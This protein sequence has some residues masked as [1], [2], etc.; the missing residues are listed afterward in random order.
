[1]DGPYAGCDLTHFRF[2]NGDLRRTF[3][4][5]QTVL[6]GGFADRGLL[7]NPF[8]FARGVFLVGIHHRSDKLRLLFRL[9][10][11]HDQG[12]DDAEDHVQD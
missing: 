3:R 5:N 9:G 2:G 12:K 6:Y 11:D 10:Q 4:L 1:M 7:L 8:L